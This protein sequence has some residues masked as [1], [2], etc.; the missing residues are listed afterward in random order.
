[1]FDVELQIDQARAVMR[2]YVQLRAELDELQARAHDQLGKAV[3]AYESLDALPEH[4][5]PDAYRATVLGAHLFGE[6]LVGEL[7][8]ANRCSEG[9][10]RMLADQVSQL[11]HKLPDCWR[12][13]GDETV[14]APIWQA[15]QVLDACAGLDEDQH[16]R[17]D[18]AVAPGLGA[19]PARRLST[20]VAAQV[21]L[22]DPHGARIKARGAQRF[23]RT[24]GDRSD[25]ASGWVQAK[26][27]RADAIFFDAALQ[28]VADALEARGDQPDPDRRRAAAIGVLAN[29]AAA[30]QLIGMCTPPAAWT[31]P[32][33]A[34][35]TPTPW[36][37]RPGA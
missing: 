4:Q 8:M 32:P 15:R 37:S 10:A 16:R 30:V 23:A 1:M 29:P 35:K 13:V 6:D 18:A 20:L 24:W 12:R 26:T 2:E 17:V 22:A 36:S 11:M 25:P 21:M 5:R 31:R 9:T 27:D 14:C 7:A 19:L 33:P 3:L 34:R 28:Q